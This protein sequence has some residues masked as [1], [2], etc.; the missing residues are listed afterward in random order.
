[1]LQLIVPWALLLLPL[2]WLLRHWLKPHSSREETLRIPFLTRLAAA[3]GQAPQNQL[4]ARRQS[5]QKVLIALIWLVVVIALARPVWQADPVSRQLPSRD[6]MLAVDISASMET[7]DMRDSNGTAISRLAALKTVLTQ[8]AE[9]RE[10]DRFGLI[11][12]GSAPFLQVPFT[13][14]SDLFTQLLEEA[15]VPMAGPKTMLGDAIG[16]ALKHFRSSSSDNKLLLLITDGNDSGSRIPPLEAARFAAEASIRIHTV[17]IGDPQS[18]GEAALDLELLKAISEQA[19]G[20][21]F[22]VRDQAQLDQLGQQLDSLEPSEMKTETRHPRRELYHWPLAVALLLTL[23][24]HTLL[25][26]RQ[27][28]RRYA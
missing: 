3:S 25:A 6:L 2:P 26:F 15:R 21:H 7:R 20:R 23:L 27:W 16:L 22:S 18:L 19:G 5:L 13:S 11:L 1:M 14:D 10:G 12:F 24:V 4:V 8:M 17:V 9:R 28:R